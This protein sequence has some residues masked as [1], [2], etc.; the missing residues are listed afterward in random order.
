MLILDCAILPLDLSLFHHGS[1]ALTNLSHSIDIKTITTLSFFGLSLGVI[2]GVGALSGDDQGRVNLLFLLLVFAFLPVLSLIISLIL[3]SLKINGLTGVIVNSP[4][5]PKDLSPTQFKFKFGP[6][7]RLW[8]FYQSQVFSLAF[9]LGSILVYL[10]LLLG[11][12]VNFV[13]RSTLLEATDLLPALNLIS[14]PWLF[15]HDAQPS[16]Q[17]L[18]L[19]QNSR[20]A[21]QPSAYSEN[22]W[23]FILAA[24][25]SYNLIP[26][27]FL[28]LIARWQYIATTEANN[29]HASQE[30]APTQNAHSLDNSPVL[31]NIVH[32]L[33][34][35]YQL[36]DWSR[37]PIHCQS[38]IT[39]S[40][41]KPVVQ[42]ELSPLGLIEIANDG[43]ST[44]IVVL[45]KSWN[46][47]LGEL[48]DILA[49]LNSAESKYILPLDWGESAVNVPSPI[50][51]KEWQRFAAT[52]LNWEILQPGEHS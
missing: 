29:K 50:H 41:G 3:A 42:T 48:K 11:T 8:M 43:Q 12:D 19:S 2:V 30:C 39:M 21:G 5:W 1:P 17:L 24:Q 4:L 35:R 27:V 40:F 25:L 6:Q 14:A 34:G 22:W 23:Q 10:A 33:P 15:W 16:L 9:A 49:T 13:W 7:R 26:R 38:F 45:V 32:T 28:L 37:S 52:L 18:Q 47:P 31:A 20:I 44:S 46:A 51:L 36:L